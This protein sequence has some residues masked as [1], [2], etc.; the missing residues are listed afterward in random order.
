MK[1]A[2]F[3]FFEKRWPSIS[4]TIIAL[5]FW[6]AGDSADIEIATIFGI[7]SITADRITDAAKAL[8]TIIAML[9]YSPLPRPV[10]VFSRKEDNLPPKDITP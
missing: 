7:S 8:T 2:L 9:G 10:N 6:V 5:I 3:N 1:E 4:A